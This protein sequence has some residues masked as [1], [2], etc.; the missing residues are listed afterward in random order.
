[1]EMTN[2]KVRQDTR[3]PRGAVARLS[4]A[5][6]LAA[7][8][9]SVASDAT[10]RSQPGADRPAALASN[11]VPGPSAAGN[12][13]AGRFAQ[14]RDDWAGSWHLLS[15]AL[16]ADLGNTELIRQGFLSAVGAGEMSE[17]VELAKRIV[18][19]DTQNYF[20]TTVLAAEEFEKGRYAEAKQRLAG[21]SARGANRLLVPLL[22]SWAE[23]GLGNGEVA[24]AQLKAASAANPLFLLHGGLI[25]DHLGNAAEAVEWFE[26]LGKRARLP[27]RSAR[28]VGAAYER[29]GQPDKARAYY[30]HWAEFGPD[31]VAGELALARMEKGEPPAKRIETARE[32]AG[33][34]FL[35][36]AAALR[37]ENANDL[38]LLYAKVADYL[39]PGSPTIQLLV[40]DILAEGRRYDE[41]I[42]HYSRV[43]RAADMWWVAQLRTADVLERA[44]RVD[45]A[46]AL[47]QRLAAD[48]PQRT[49]ALTAKG[50][51]LRR[52][53]RYDEA[54]AAYAEALAR[55]PE[56]HQR[57]WVLF[58]ARGVSLERADR[59]AEA[60][61]DLLKALE[62]Q[63]NH[64]QILN[65]LAYA[66]ADQGVNLDRAHEM[67][68]RAVAIRPN[69]GH[70]IDSLGW[71]L[72]RLGRYDEAVV[73][74]EKA[75]ELE[76]QEAEVNE[77]L[78]DVYWQVGRQLE[79]RF[80][81]RRALQQA[82]DDKVVARIA[83]KL[84][85]GLAASG[86][87]AEK[88]PVPR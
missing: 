69:D 33:E 81:W 26:Q 19:F 54:V 14:R 65:Y 32:G 56:V 42:A 49:D 30:E 57:H 85:H 84:D 11:I 9:I 23:A 50:D 34:A 47:L 60:E 80:Q 44:E 43:D 2:L 31:V 74:L 55:V 21:M 83:E 58:Y 12:Y 13:L 3:R 20:A 51:L 24:L 48:F 6:A 4:G 79:A 40:G 62:L 53:K 45:E 28:L 8:A 39:R 63:P 87:T 35:D 77:H 64:P 67:L 76:P 70:I 71:V 5:L 68:Q 82:K 41:A 29:A 88:G 72:Y 86:K 10:A 22:T 15:A 17:A 36:L 27:G 16:R 18:E 59:W 78:G 7:L 75:I 1:M 46:V 38:A 37:Q 66:W 73:K 25:A 52:A 61:K